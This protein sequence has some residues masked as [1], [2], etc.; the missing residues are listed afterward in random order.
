VENYLEGYRAD[1]KRKVD[2]YQRKL[3]RY[4]RKAEG[5]RPS[6]SKG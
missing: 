1:I 4:E 5:I 3:S 6:Q 2:R